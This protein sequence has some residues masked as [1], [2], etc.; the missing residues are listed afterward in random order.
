MR[1]NR[2]AGSI[3]PNPSKGTWRKASTRISSIRRQLEVAEALGVLGDAAIERLRQSLAVIR[4]LQQRLLARVAQKA[5]FGQHAGHV[6]A[7]QHHKRSLLDAAVLLPGQVARRERKKSGL[8]AAGEF[9]GFVEFLVQRDLLN[10]V[11]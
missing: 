6:G 3:R 10:D 1:R 11:L 7:D 8:D 4:L 9:A 5:D 2:S